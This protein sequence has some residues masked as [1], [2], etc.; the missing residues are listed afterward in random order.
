[1][2][3]RL[4]FEQIKQLTDPAIFAIIAK[5][6]IAFY[7]VKL[8]FKG[9]KELLK[10]IFVVKEKKDDYKDLQK[11]NLENKEEIKQLKEAFEKANIANQKRDE[12]THK[13]IKQFMLEN[14]KKI[15]KLE[16]NLNAYKKVKHGKDNEVEEA[17]K[18]M[19]LILEKLTTNKL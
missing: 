9:L 2:D 16:K 17:R 5:F 7:S 14:E 12:E 8:L 4:F 13:L 11:T 3:F 18:T 1:M 10:F 6:A 15:S 19:K